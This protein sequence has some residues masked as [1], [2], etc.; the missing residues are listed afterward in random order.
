[1]YRP[2]ENCVFLIALCPIFTHPK[3]IF[4]S[5]RNNNDKSIINPIVGSN[6]LYIT[7]FLKKPFQYCTSSAIKDGSIDKTLGATGSPQGK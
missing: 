7:Q 5:I 3:M 4:E 2:I 6:N 1:M